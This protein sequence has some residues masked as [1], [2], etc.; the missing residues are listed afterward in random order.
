MMIPVPDRG[1]LRRVEG[2]EAARAVP[3]VEEIVMS[4]AM[5]TPV[6][7]LPEGDRYLGFIFVRDRTPDAVER[8]LRAAFNALSVTIE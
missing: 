2:L 7:P 4:V 6:E 5:G 8:G 3:A 1:V